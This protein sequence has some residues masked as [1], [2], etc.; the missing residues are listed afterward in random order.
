MGCTSNRLAICRPDAESYSQVVE[1][2]LTEQAIP[3][4]GASGRI[5]SDKTA[6]FKAQLL[7]NFIKSLRTEWSSILSYALISNERAKR[8]VKPM[9]HSIGRFEIGSATE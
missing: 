7:Q 6:C 3:D 8:I 1:G 9:K 2:F 4:F 5:V